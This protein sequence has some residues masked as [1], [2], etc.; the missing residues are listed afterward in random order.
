MHV[1]DA[2]ASMEQF[3]ATAGH[4]SVLMSYSAT[5]YAK[6]PVAQ[7]HSGSQTQMAL[8]VH[9]CSNK[10]ESIQFTSSMRVV[11]VIILNVY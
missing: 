2:H 3:Q 7:E 11:T 6:V 9:K 4:Y 5:V 10:T 1:N 8:C